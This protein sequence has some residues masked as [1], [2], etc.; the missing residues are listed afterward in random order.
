[1]RRANWVW[2]SVLVLCLAIAGIASVRSP[3]PPVPGRQLHLSKVEVVDPRYGYLDDDPKAPYLIDGS[4]GFQWYNEDAMNPD[5]SRFDS[6]G[7][8]LIAYVDGCAQINHLVLN[9]SG[10]PMGIKIYQPKETLVEPIPFALA[11]WEL[12]TDIPD[13]PSVL[14]LDVPTIHRCYFMVQLYRL[15][16]AP[17]KTQVYR[18]GVAEIRAY[19]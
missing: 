17:G 4:M 13:A 16:L 10:N 15:P 14:T 9:L 5:Y 12:V 3:R 11:D 1:M 7:F 6:G 2:V 8:N 19:Q 18:A